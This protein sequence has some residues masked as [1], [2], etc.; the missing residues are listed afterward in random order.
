MK[1]ITT[2]KLERL[3]SRAATASIATAVILSII[4]AAAALLT[5]SLAILSS[6]I[7]S[8]TDVFSSI[9][10]YIAV[11]Y[12]AKPLTAKHKYGYGRAEALS[13]LLQ[14]AFI[15]GSAFFILY[16]A[17]YR[18]F[19]GLSLHTT[20]LG[21]AIMLVCMLLTLLLLIYQKRVIAKT[22]SQA[23]IADNLH[24]KVDLLA[25]LAVIC[26]L[27][28]V[29]YLDWQWFDILT[30]LLLSAY[31]LRSAAKIAINALEEITDKEIDDSLKQQILQIIAGIPEIKGY[32]DFRSRISG[33]RTFVEIHLEFDGRKTLYNTHKIADL[34]ENLIISKFPHIQII[35]HQDPHGIQEKRLDN[36]VGKNI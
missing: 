34:A 16:E 21:I 7:D 15:C 1:S 22:N 26:S 14:T 31:L 35:I 29:K 30:A 17:V 11:Q 32:H 3:K 5:G 13:A 10:T 33:S 9:I 18:L 6:M 2:E 8:L 24:Y 23:I 19:H 28:V 4:K 27:C 36:D 25:N 20:Y 12:S